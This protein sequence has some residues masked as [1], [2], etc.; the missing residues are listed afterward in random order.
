MKNFILITTLFATTSAF[1]SSMESCD[2]LYDNILVSFTNTLDDG[3]SRDIFDFW[4]QQS[5]DNADIPYFLSSEFTTFD[6]SFTYFSLEPRSYASQCSSH[7]ECGKLAV[8]QITKIVSRFT[9]NVAS[10][11]C[12]VTQNPFPRISVGNR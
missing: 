1:A 8:E 12:D 5:G 11:E 9:P 4:L 10:V 2:F 3:R 6:N 7:I